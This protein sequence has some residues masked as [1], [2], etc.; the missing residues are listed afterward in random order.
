MQSCLALSATLA[1]IFLKSE[2]TIGK[3]SAAPAYTKH[4]IIHSITKTKSTTKE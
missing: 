3:T 1:A 2:S 4:K